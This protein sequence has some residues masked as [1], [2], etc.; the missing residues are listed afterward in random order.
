MHFV[1]TVSA[2][3]L[4]LLVAPAPAARLS[5][6][7]PA[8]G[9]TEGIF[10]FGTDAR[11]I[12]LG[13][14]GT[15]KPSGFAALYWNPA[16]LDFV[17]R[18]E[19]GLFHTSFFGEVPYDYASFAFPT[20]RMGTFGAGVFRTGVDGIR[21]YDEF[22]VSAGTFSFSQEEFLLGYGKRLLEGGSAGALL[23][24]DHQSMLGSSATG[25]GLD[26]A[27]SYRLPW[28]IA[29]LGE[30]RTGVVFRNLLAPSLK[31]ASTSNDYPRALVVGVGT[32][33]EL[34]A[35]HTIA[36]MFDLEKAAAHDLRLRLGV[37]YG[38]H[39]YLAFRGGFNE[40]A[41]ALGIGIRLKRGMG[42]DYAMRESRE[43]DIPTQH[44]FSVT[45]AFGLSRAE[46]LD[47]ERKRQE[48]RIEREVQESFE[49]R[50]RAEVERHVQAARQFFEASDYFSSLSE[51]QQVLAWDADNVEAHQAIR[52]I[53][54]TL[55]RLQEARNV[56]AATR[57]ASQE[58]FDVGIRYYTEK[59]YP[60]AIA[61]WERV[62][63]IDPDHALSRDYIERAA[64]EV[65]SLL[66]THSGRAGRL[67]RA[68]DYT[69]ALNEYHVAL[70]YD[71][72]NLDV[73]RGIK[74]VQNM[75]RS[76][77]AFREGLTHYLNEDFESAAASFRR[78]IELNPGNAMVRDYLAA[79][80]SRMAGESTELRPDV[81]K[82][83][84]A[85]VDLYLQGRYEEAIA[86]WERI[87]EDDP[88]NLRVQRNI[89]AA[90]ER[91]KT[92][93]ELGSRE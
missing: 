58:L 30:V 28:E 36:P 2:G 6:D 77:E 68:G 27:F 9:G 4:A 7:T 45:Y 56:D 83:Y 5:A 55:N 61:S 89:D 71:P 82:D 39:P 31:L 85:G 24:V 81:E 17:P 38:Y 35:D 76:N 86:I 91:M 32:E 37:E 90:R 74:R 49:A 12:G 50:K 22:G 18:M 46:R 72:Q 34:A 69:G 14:V 67:I 25:V 66:K 64:A 41:T 78:A 52:E 1:R 3:L 16:Y 88:H 53:A 93:E 26:A 44:L 54:D 8:D 48:E 87:L 59:R 65:R 40:S 13:G 57:V 21:G 80:E 60:E 42:F 62:L 15:A 63:E 20:L 33:I 75:I 19:A 73:L 47:L 51:W 10:S 79:V 43:S 11:A 29:G 23:K 92:I 84:L 70:R